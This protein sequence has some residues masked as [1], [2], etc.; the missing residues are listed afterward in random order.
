MKRSG[1]PNRPA[2]REA[3]AA[4][5]AEPK[6]E[7][8]RNLRGDPEPGRFGI[9]GKLQWQ[10]DKKPE[11]E[12]EPAPAAVPVVA[13]AE[14]DSGITA[15]AFLRFVIHLAGS[16]IVGAIVVVIA[17]VVADTVTDGDFVLLETR[18]LPVF[19]A[20]ATSIILFALLRTGK[21]SRGWSRAETVT[22]VIVGFVALVLG[23]VLLYQPSIMA[24]A[25]EQLS[26][27]LGGVYSEAD[28]T[29]VD[30]V[31]A[32]LGAWNG[33]VDRYKEQLTSISELRKNTGLDAEALN[34]G[35]DR[36]RV[37]MSENN[38][39]L[40]GV[41]T[42]MRSRAERADDPDLQTALANIAGFYDQQLSGIRAITQGFPAGN[43]T[44]VDNGNRRWTQAR[45]S[46]TA[47]FESDLRALLE[48]GDLDVNEFRTALTA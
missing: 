39:E 20:G 30:Q 1:R 43:S 40:A 34:A 18:G 12:P 4:A 42:Q 46:A 13:T 9:G 33:G 3:V 27:A 38:D 7:P 37:E 22:S 29:A 36:V 45:D 35:I 21:R 25:Q 44:L 19:I 28:E 32:S 47:Y 17:A 24:D 5:E 41:L 2:L 8:I 16:F 26:K 10:E 31:R 14:A 48:R 23:S 15:G 6:T 11:L